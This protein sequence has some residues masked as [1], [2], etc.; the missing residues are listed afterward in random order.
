MNIKRSAAL[1]MIAVLLLC[2]L[3]GC[4]DGQGFDSDTPSVAIIIKGSESDFWNDVKKGA[5]SAATEF[6][7][8]ITFEGPDNEE[9]Y[10]T[11]NRMIENA[12]SRNVGAII[13]SAI[14]YEKNAPAV[15]KAAEKGIKIITVDSDVD[16]AD[17]ELFIATDNYSA[18]LKTAQVAQ[19]LC[20]EQ[21]SINIG[22]VNYGENTENGSKRLQGFQDEIKNVKNARIVAMVSVSS[23]AQSAT[24]G[25]RKLLE[26]NP[27]IN[28]LV[29]FNEWSTL[30]VGMAIKELGLKDRVCAIGFDNN[31]EC[32][33]MLETGELDTLIVQNPFS[34]GYLSG[35]QAER[36]D[37]EKE[38]FGA[39]IARDTEQYAK[40]VLENDMRG[41]TTVRP[42]HQQVGNR[43]E[44]WR[45][46]LVP[47]WVMTYKGK[48]GKIYYYT[49]NG[50][51][52]KVCG[53]LPVDYKKLSLVS[54]LI[55]G[56]VFLLGLAGGLLL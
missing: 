35:F 2:G 11:Q 29:G 16:V 45:Y 9:D 22:I 41:Y 4:E 39:E 15:R 55:T 8:D 12:V 53:E 17:K 6:N 28:V 25:A 10:E 21:E 14:D 5:L 1:I 13:L 31:T 34:M 50:Q 46:A 30:G 44:R 32:V 36:R 52:G 47:V 37:L 7:I 38:A 18:G 48:N 20:G 43:Q 19:K 33:G 23:N 56:V 26:E 54:A 40:R 51:N 3:S 42:V 24:A 27:Q 49:I